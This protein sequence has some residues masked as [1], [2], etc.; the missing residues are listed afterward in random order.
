ML[1]ISDELDVAVSNVKAKLRSIIIILQ[2]SNKLMLIRVEKHMERM[3]LHHYLRKICFSATSLR[4]R[5]RS[6]FV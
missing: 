3:E 2:Q 6:M 1:V 4:I 5:C